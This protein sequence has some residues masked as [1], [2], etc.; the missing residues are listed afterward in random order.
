MDGTNTIERTMSISHI[1]QVLWLLP[2][3]LC[4]ESDLALNGLGTVGVWPDSDPSCVLALAYCIRVLW[5][6]S[7]YLSYGG[8]IAWSIWT[9]PAI[10]RILLPK[11]LALIVIIR[12]YAQN[13]RV[14]GWGGPVWPPCGPWQRHRE[15]QHY[16]V[17]S[18]G[19]ALLLWKV[20]ITD[21]LG[22]A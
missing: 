20:S 4:E 5:A 22:I 14:V 13:E 2:W 6:L 16:E 1:E 19:V 11:R 15:L 12:P 8:L 21:V 9:M 10:L 18:V 7:R 17:L 3:W